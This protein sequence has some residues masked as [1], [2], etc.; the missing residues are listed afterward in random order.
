MTLEELRRRA[1]NAQALKDHVAFQEVT[2]AIR[3]EAA[4]LFLN[5]GTIGD[6]VQKA[7]SL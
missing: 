1:E 4:T 2:K 3:N 7:H 6:D 5:S